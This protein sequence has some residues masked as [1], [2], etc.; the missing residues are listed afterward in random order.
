MATLKNTKIDD[1]GFLTLPDGN[2]GQRP[3][4]AISG[5]LRF[6][7]DEGKIEGYDGSNWIIIS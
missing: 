1:T 7:T 5:M 3:G 2:T 6:N 4:T